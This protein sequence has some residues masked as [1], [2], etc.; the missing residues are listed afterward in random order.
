LR[1]LRMTSYLF[2]NEVVDYKRARSKQE[3][4]KEA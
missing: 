3:I 4:R 2:G 1:R